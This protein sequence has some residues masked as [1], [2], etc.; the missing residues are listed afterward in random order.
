M[1]GII[2]CISTHLAAAAVICVA[3]IGLGAALV[4]LAWPHR[5]EFDD[6]ND[7]FP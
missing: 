5:I 4:Y 6:E 7:F 2:D 3:A 1:I